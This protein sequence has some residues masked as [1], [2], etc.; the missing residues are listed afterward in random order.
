MSV[1]L[2]CIKTV[3]EYCGE[4]NVCVWTAC[5][6]GG[7]TQTQAINLVSKT[8]I[9]LTHS[10]LQ[11]KVSPSITSSYLSGTWA[12]YGLYTFFAVV[13]IIVLFHILCLTVTIIYFL[14]PCF[15]VR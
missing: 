8:K 9:L 5:V 6:S 3:L 1:I 15:K 11:Q 12:C 10:S 14:H 13:H 2:R 4:G 7:A